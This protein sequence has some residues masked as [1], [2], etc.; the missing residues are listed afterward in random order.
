MITRFR[1]RERV[2]DGDNSFPPKISH[3]R[4]TVVVFS[5]G[6]V[7]DEGENNPDEIVSRREAIQ[8]LSILVLPILEMAETKSDRFE[9]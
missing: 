5:R 3:F 4:R 2:W 8:P 9:G 6:I 7:E 1:R